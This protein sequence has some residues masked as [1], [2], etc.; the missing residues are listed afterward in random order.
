[1]VARRPV[2]LAE[3]K[4]S[5]DGWPEYYDGK[6]G[7]FVGKQARKHLTWSIAGYLVAKM[8]LEDPTHLGMVAMEE[9]K[10]SKPDETSTMK[11]L[12]TPSRYG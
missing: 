5:K 10:R 1:M 11:V 2:E 12:S 7:R 4:L 6:R 8:M 3:A 9:E